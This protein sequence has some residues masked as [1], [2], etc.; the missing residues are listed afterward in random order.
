MCEKAQD[1]EIL[2]VDEVRQI[3]EDRR[4]LG[5]QPDS[6]RG[7][8]GYQNWPDLSDTRRTFLCVDGKS[9]RRSILG[10]TFNLY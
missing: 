4:Q 8:P 5:I 10:Q 2:T 3:L 9:Q 6:Q 1:Q 7:V